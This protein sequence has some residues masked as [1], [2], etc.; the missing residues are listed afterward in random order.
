MDDLLLPASDT[1]DNWFQG[2]EE[3]DENDEETESE[4]DDDN[5]EED[6]M[7]E[8]NSSDE[9]KAV[10]LVNGKFKMNGDDHMESDD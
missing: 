3:E 7:E 5:E 2:E 6:N 9:D 10:S 8:L 4:E 1:D